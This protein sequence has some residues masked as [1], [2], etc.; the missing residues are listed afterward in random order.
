M[1]DHNHQHSIPTS[2][3][4]ENNRMALFAQHVAAHTLTARVADKLPT[5]VTVNVPFV[6][7]I[8]S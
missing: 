1:R 7:P 3:V 6:I 8:L 2:P 5:A 4:F